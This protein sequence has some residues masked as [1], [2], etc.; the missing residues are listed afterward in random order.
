APDRY[1]ATPHCR[2]GRCPR[3]SVSAARGPA[4]YMSR[5]RSSRHYYGSD[6]DDGGT[7]Y[8]ELEPTTASVRVCTPTR[9]TLCAPAVACRGTD[10]HARGTRR[11]S[12]EMSWLTGVPVT[13]ECICVAH[14]EV[15]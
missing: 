7:N 1:S 2:R 3:T 12:A 6:R 11:W 8:R 4:N 14:Q 9:R 15:S 10:T 5:P 13:V